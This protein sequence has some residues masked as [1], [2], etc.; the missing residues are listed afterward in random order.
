MRRRCADLSKG[1][2]EYTV[3]QS[4]SD[5]VIQT[6]ELTLSFADQYQFQINL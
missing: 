5:N 6:L 1:N 4:Y 3:I 2:D